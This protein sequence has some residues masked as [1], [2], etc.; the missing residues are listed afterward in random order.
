M[1]CSIFRRKW[2]LTGIH[3]CFY[4]TVKA[5]GTC[6]FKVN[7][8]WR[9]THTYTRHKYL[10]HHTLVYYTHFIYSYTTYIYSY[11]PYIY[12]FTPYIYSY[13]PTIHLLSYTI[14]YIYLIHHTFTLIHHTFTLIHHS[15]TLIHHTFTL[16]HHT[17]IS[18][19]WLWYEYHSHKS[20]RYTVGRTL[21]HFA[22]C[23]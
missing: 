14:L 8:A 21:A 2:R 10:L 20:L 11:T 12:S 6:I 19:I 17:F 23:I 4:N 16:I 9:V 13:T 5:D 1:H 15:F 22:L 7:L 18:F 3:I